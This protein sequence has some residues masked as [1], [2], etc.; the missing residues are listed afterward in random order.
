MDTS[1]EYIA[2]CRQAINYLPEHE[3]DIGDYYVRQT[4]VCTNERFWKSTQEPNQ[5]EGHWKVGSWVQTPGVA[6]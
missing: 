4:H 2:M 1:E 5:E 6:L 3:W